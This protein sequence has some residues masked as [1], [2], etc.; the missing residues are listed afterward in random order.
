MTVNGAKS[1]TGSGH[2]F[3]RRVGLP[4]LSG[5]LSLGH[6]QVGPNHEDL[7]KGQTQ[8]AVLLAINAQLTSLQGSSPSALTA[9]RASR[10]PASDSES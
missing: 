8:Q 6:A 5:N 4:A 9:C 3:G 7:Q 10:S 1:D 2:E